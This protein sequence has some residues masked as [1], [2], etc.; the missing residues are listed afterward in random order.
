[1]R[2]GKWLTDKQAGDTTVDTA[3]LD[4]AADVKHKEKVTPYVEDRRNIVVLRLVNPVPLT[5]AVTLRSALERAIETEFQLEDSELDSRALPDLDDKGRML[6]TEAA[7]GGA[8]VL[9]RLVEEPAVLAAVARRA[10]SIIH[11]DP[12]TGDDL[13]KAPNARERCEKGCYDCLLSYSNQY[14]HTLIDRHTIV[15]LLQ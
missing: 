15:A 13:N 9:G 2:E 5:V 4:D 8:G 7:E 10:M 1:L 6:L 12:D 11:Y 14:E 3:D